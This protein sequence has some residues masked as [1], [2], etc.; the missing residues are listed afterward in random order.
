MVKNEWIIN[1]IKI[2]GP[3]W[4]RASWVS[5]SDSWI[6]LTMTWFY[7]NA[8]ELYYFLPAIWWRRH[9]YWG[10][11]DIYRWHCCHIGWNFVFCPKFDLCRSPTAILEITG[12]KFWTIKFCPK[13]HEK[14]L[15]NAKNGRN[16]TVFR[17]KFFQ[18]VIIVL[19]FFYRALAAIA[20]LMSDVEKRVLKMTFLSARVG[21][22]SSL[23]ITMET[24]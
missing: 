19:M 14:L 11:F 20:V 2:N 1:W 6:R 8:K 5:R 16:L 17:L 24:L 13:L 9:F 4:K 18:K 15:Q 3:S 21:T 10:K 12:T 7:G 23:F 22:Y